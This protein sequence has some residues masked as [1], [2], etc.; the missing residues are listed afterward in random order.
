[1]APPSGP[2][3]GLDKDVIAVRTFPAQSTKTGKVPETIAV[4]Y[5][6]FST[7]TGAVSKDGGAHWQQHAMLDFG[8]NPLQVLCSGAAIDSR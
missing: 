3:A 7:L 5:D 4:C 2:D 6:D 1:L 8:Y